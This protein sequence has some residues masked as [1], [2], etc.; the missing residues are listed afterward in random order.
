MFLMAKI[1]LE[2]KLR[3]GTIQSGLLRSY[4]RLEVDSSKQEDDDGFNQK[5]FDMNS[6]ICELLFWVIANDEWHVKNNTEHYSDR[7]EKK[8]EGAGELL[9]LRHAYNASKHNMG[10]VSLFSFEGKVDFIKGSGLIISDPSTPAVWIN[11]PDDEK[12]KNQVE[13]YRDYLKDKNVLQTFDDAIAFLNTEN[14][15]IRFA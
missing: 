6:S 15:K 2:K 11:C 1:E 13:N 5:V 4:K 7:R 12:Y 3:F 14:N 9:G 8:Q 10:Y